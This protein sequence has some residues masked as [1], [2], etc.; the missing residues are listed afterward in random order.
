MK[1]FLTFAICLA[2]VIP[3]FC[4]S[5]A[6]AKDQQDKE[7]QLRTALEQMRNAIDHYRGMADR[8]KI[9]TPVGSR[10]YPPDLDALV[11]GASDAHGKT[12]S[13]PE[14]DSSRS[15]DGK[16][17]LGPEKGWAT[18][19]YIRRLHQIRSYSSG[20]HQISRLVNSPQLDNG[21]SL[22]QN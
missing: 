12:I 4:Q 20:W 2:V 16:Y 13:V 21:D 9:M 15:H 3:T 5:S 7:R 17:G 22:C 18:R 10:N 8:G 19:R 6:A 1:A 11:K 14:Q